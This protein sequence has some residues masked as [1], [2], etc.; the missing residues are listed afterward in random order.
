MSTP[1]AQPRKEIEV[2]PAPGLK[3]PNP[4]DAGADLSADAW[5]RVPRNRYWSRR[6]AQGD[7]ILR[8]QQAAASTT[9]KAAASADA[10]Q[11][12]KKD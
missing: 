12:S 10:K 5:T 7:V 1:T 11:T 6:L 3:V 2:K 8:G 4:E 9:G